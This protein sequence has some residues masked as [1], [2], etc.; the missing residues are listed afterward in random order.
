MISD[1][2][3]KPLSSSSTSSSATC[4]STTSCSSN[5]L[6]LLLSRFLLLLP[7][8]LL[9][10]SS[11]ACPSST[12]WTHCVLGPLPLQL[13]VRLASATWWWEREVGGEGPK[14]QVSSWKKYTAIDGNIAA[15]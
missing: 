1:Q 6:L 4:S 14:L 15:E 2:T 10:L 7:F 8:L 13:R 3:H 11:A 12:S 5:H 9:P